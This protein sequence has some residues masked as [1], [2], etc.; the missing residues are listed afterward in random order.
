MAGG[1]K[2]GKDFNVSATLATAPPQAVLDAASDPAAMAHLTNSPDLQAQMLDYTRTAVNFP[3]PIAEDGSV[4]VEDVPPGT[5]MFSACAFPSSLT[6]FDRA[7]SG[8][9]AVITIPAD[10]PTGTIDAG[11][12]PMTKQ[13]I[14]KAQ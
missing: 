12:V 1:G 2:P 7:L 10:P 8:R 11:D 6:Q 4:I 9:S 3:A 14:A 13:S 5:Y